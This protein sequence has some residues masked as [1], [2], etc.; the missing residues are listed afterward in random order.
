MLTAFVSLVLP[1]LPAQ[2]AALEAAPPQGEATVTAAAR[3][4]PLFW[5]LRCDIGPGRDELVSHRPWAQVE[6][7]DAGGEFVRVEFRA[8]SFENRFVPVRAAASQQFSWSAELT[9][10]RVVAVPGSYRLRVQWAVAGDRA[11]RLT[12]WREF[13]IAAAPAELP[14]AVAAAAQN[15]T[16]KAYEACMTA[17]LRFP[18]L[19]MPRLPLPEGGEGSRALLRVLE[20]EQRA[21]VERLRLVPELPAGVRARLDVL[22][23]VRETRLA[24]APGDAALRRAHWTMVDALAGA[25]TKRPPPRFY[26]ELAALAQ[27]GAW[28]ELDLH[29]DVRSAWWSEERIAVAIGVP[30]LQ[31]LLQR[32]PSSATGAPTGPSPSLPWPPPRN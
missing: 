8:L 26:G 12:P 9:D 32:P 3:F 22:D 5:T 24:V 4:E 2:Q 14:L 6:R 1:A 30:E 29:A 20:S 15:E 11:V 17:P 10:P 19:G 16:W 23:V 25:A 7:K 21:A 13:V 18:V 28:H 27:L 31:S